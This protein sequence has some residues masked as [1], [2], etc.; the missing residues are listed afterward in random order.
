MF[1]FLFIFYCYTSVSFDLGHLYNKSEGQKVT[2]KQ[3]IIQISSLRPCG[4]SVCLS[5]TVAD[6]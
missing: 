2:L 1:H 6:A 5:Q 4:I 3:K